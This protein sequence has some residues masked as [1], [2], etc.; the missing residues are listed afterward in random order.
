MIRGRKP[1]DI[2]LCFLLSKMLTSA[3]FCFFSA[4]LNL[5]GFELCLTGALRVPQ[6]KTTVCSQAVHADDSAPSTVTSYKLLHA[7]ACNRDL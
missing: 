5:D 7:L 4:R 6:T 1:T 3:M 2:L